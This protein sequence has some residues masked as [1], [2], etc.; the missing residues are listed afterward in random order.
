MQTY[1]GSTESSNKGKSWIVR[2]SESGW[3]NQTGFGTVHQFDSAWWGGMT[4]CR[5]AVSVLIWVIL[6]TLCFITVFFV[7]GTAV[8]NYEQPAIDDGYSESAPETSSIYVSTDQTGN[9]DGTNGYK[10]CVAQV[11]LS[12]DVVKPGDEISIEVTI[13]NRGERLG[14]VKV[15]RGVEWSDG[16]TDYAAKSYS[17]IPVGGTQTKT[18]SYTVPD[19]A[20][21]G[22]YSITLDVYTPQEEFMFDT[23]GFVHQFEV[24]NPPSS[25]REDPTNADVIVAAN[26]EQQFEVDASDTDGD[27]GGV[28]WYVD[29]SFITE[30]RFSGSSA[31]DTFSRAFSSPGT[32]T[33]EAD[34]FDEHRVYNDQAA[35]WTVEVEQG[36]PDLTVTDVELD[37]TSPDA[38][39]EVDFQ[40][41]LENTG[42]NGASTIESEVQ[43]DGQSVAVPPTTSLAPGESTTTAWTGNYEFESGTHTVTA[44]VDPDDLISES[45]ESNN[46]ESISVD[47]EARYGAV[48]GQVTDDQ[49]SPVS[50]AKVYLDPTTDTR[51]SDNGE[52][53]FTDV[54]EGEY[55]LEVISSQHE[56]A[57]ATV[58]VT[59]S[60]TTKQDFEIARQLPDLEVTSVELDPSSPDPGETVD[61]RIGLEN[62]GTVAAETIES[63]V[64]VDGELAAVPP[65]TSLEP[66]ESTT[67]AWSGSYEF[68]E[69][70]HTITATA[71]PDNNIAESNENN[72]QQS[73]RVDS[74]TQTG[75]LTVTAENGNEEIVENAEIIL[76]EENQDGWN[77]IGAK[78]TDSSGQARWSDLETGIYNV[79]L[80]GPNGD[81]WGTEV[82]IEVD[83]DGAQT[84]IQREAPRLKTITLSE[85]NND[86]RYYVGETINISPEIQNEGPSRPVQVYIQIDTDNDD[87]AE[88]TIP[89]GGQGTTIES[90]EIGYYGYAYQPSTAGVK[91]VK[92][93][94]EAYIG[95]E[96]VPTDHSNWARRFETNH[97]I[98]GY[99][100]QTNNYDN[101]TVSSS[102]SFSWSTPSLPDEIH[103]EYT[104][105]GLSYDNGR[106]NLSDTPGLSE[107]YPWSAVGSLAITSPFR[108][109]SS[110]FQDFGSVCSGTVIQ[111]NHIITAAHCV[112]D[113]QNPRWING[114]GSLATPVFSP[115]RSMSSFQYDTYNV[116]FVHTYD[117]WI[118]SQN[119]SYDIAVLT[120]NESV[121]SE[122][123]TFGYEPDLS[124]DY[125]AHITGYPSENDAEYVSNH[126][127]QWDII[128][129]IEETDVSFVESCV[130]DLCFDYSTGSSFT[131]LTANGTSGGPVWRTGSNDLPSIVATH[132]GVAGFELDIGQDGFGP[133]MTPVKQ[134]EI[135]HMINDGNDI[136]SPSLAVSTTSTNVG[137]SVNFDASESQDSDGS[138]QKYEWDFNGDGVTDKT[139][140]SASIEYTYKTHG[141]YRAS[142]TI[143]DSDGGRATTVRTIS[144]SRNVPEFRDQAVY[145][146]GYAGTLATDEAAADRFFERTDEKDINTVFMSWGAFN[147]ASAA[148][149]AAFIERAHENDLQVHALIGTAG[150][151]AGTNAEQ[152]IP[153][154]IAYNDG[155]SSAAQFDGIHLDVEPGQADLETFLDNY[156]TMLDGARTQIQSDSG[157]S[158]NS[159]GMALSSA[160]G[161]WWANNAPTKT[162]QVVEQNALDYV[163]V[164]AYWDTEEEV[165]NR[166][167]NIVSNTD[168]PYVVGVETQEF[169]QDGDDRVTF[170]EEGE[171]AADAALQSIAVDPPSSEHIGGAYHF[172]QSS[173]S[174][175]DALKNAE[176][177]NSSI[178]PD[179]TVMIN[180]DVAFDDN[181]PEASH[182]SQV[183]VQ[184]KGQE[185]T[186]TSSKTIS[187]PNSQ[188]TT[189]AVE[190]SPPSDISPGKYQVTVSLF[191]PTFED[192]D[193]EVT[194]TR[195]EPIQLDKITAGTVSIE[196]QS[197][198]DPTPE[199]ETDSGTET[200]SDAESDADSESRSDTQTDTS[201]SEIASCTEI[202]SSGT[203]EL[204]SDLEPT[205]PAV[206]GETSGACIRIAASDV[207]LEG[208]GNAVIG[209][210]REET[211]GILVANTEQISAENVTI[212][213]LR[214]ERWANGIRIGFKGAQGD[215]DLED[216]TVTENTRNGIDVTY[217]GSA[218]IEAVEAN[219]NDNNGIAVSEGTTDLISNVTANGNG[220]SGLSLSETREI[221]VDRLT[222]SNNAESGIL[223]SADVYSSEF[224]EVYASN[225]TRSGISLGGGSNSNRF[226]DSIIEANGG[227]GVRHFDSDENEFQNVTL[228]DN[229]GRQVET[230]G[231]DRQDGWDRFTAEGLQIGDAATVTFEGEALLLDEVNQDELS[232]LPGDTEPMG[233]A[234]EIEGLNNSASMTFEYSEDGS[235]SEDEVEL[236]RREGTEWS[237][238][239]SDVT[240]TNTRIEASLTRDGVYVPVQTADSGDETDDQDGED[241]PDRT[242]GG[243]TLEIVAQQE[244]DFDYRIT[245]EG[246]ASGT[247]SGGMEADDGDQV[248]EHNDGTTTILGSTGSFAGDA[249]TIDGSIVA[250][251][252]PGDPDYE[253]QLDG[254]DVTDEV[255]DDASTLNIIAEQ[256]ADFEFRV[257]VEGDAWKT[258]TQSPGYSADSEES[259]TTEDGTTVVTGSTGGRA[260]DAFTIDGTITSVDIADDAEYRLVLDG[261]EIDPEELPE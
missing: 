187:P 79:E 95:N 130:N 253:L 78:R 34:V 229:Q 119:W 71:D 35:K 60:D 215:A 242:V 135:G 147:S 157:A 124:T 250:F 185:E 16:N 39:Q 227:P 236:Y 75:S 14:T 13:E 141:E 6:P 182:Q 151:D 109:G 218:T 247:S 70:S 161:W 156:R 165:R 234:I 15:S 5:D 20:P 131:E 225:N 9:C 230:N 65:T 36:E 174:T 251:V 169:P 66:G 21:S 51:T 231:Y 97:E 183:V 199:T 238:V 146:W 77:D 92:V 54:P 260:G 74:Q 190:W 61:F 206:N 252:T 99:D 102:Q 38:G 22:E 197:G 37:P 116:T 179:E 210:G 88:Q 42:N 63:E 195:S 175:W 24:S 127:E 110:Q 138:I 243:G 27:L 10:F 136:P 115:G 101:M 48:S 128:A 57:S 220:G 162:E 205:T 160:V 202:T 177:A 43:V 86:N 172:Y 191:D 46:E 89:R 121:A 223:F 241:T 80:Y 132:S 41:T 173:V 153:E 194:A 149:R 257:T 118:H 180:V 112:Y 33:V 144:V 155:Q 11:S 246:E 23:T 219:R 2:R 76:Y 50:G 233:D 176:A 25:N 81:Y 4:S 52:Y 96:W 126:A 93:V 235:G 258:S 204:A 196:E 245:V 232:D 69:G 94:T 207:V 104:P 26:T 105:P 237:P 98:V 256:E 193:R 163:V 249:F 208:N 72:N 188:Q 3:E 30:E 59:A 203:Y 200:D 17:D 201:P 56:D 209:T 158:I 192:E 18:Y 217:G 91:Q 248:I 122:T 83:S 55:N 198:P 216:V 239:E 184:F 134:N 189:T 159:Q 145:V 129:E 212:R 32:Y 111:D 67:T 133:R 106:R 221:T 178:G 12:Q 152:T 8:A 261:E 125:N 44:V 170:Y 108:R 140:S 143:V 40:M 47:V 259:I 103:S 224:S 82:D 186:Y 181:F 64:R 148:D 244:S 107:E 167:S 45:D 90:G 85:Q 73:R 226:R 120:L 62:V 150:S 28:E 29:G 142:V 1:V 114:F 53:E 164:M 113:D 100:P 19:S 117:K 58:Q 168:T 213:N 214:A 123:G 171:A 222:A 87:T 154:V 166:L 137:Q 7:S 228:R 254:V 255:N 31:Q 49:G 84:T 139:T 211:V 240:V 68:N